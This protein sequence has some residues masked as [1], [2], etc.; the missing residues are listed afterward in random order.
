MKIYLLAVVLASAAVAY[1]IFRAL[2]SRRSEK[3]WK[4]Q[5]RDKEE[6]EQPKEEE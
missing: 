5:M 4:E 6:E 1:V 2:F 3:L